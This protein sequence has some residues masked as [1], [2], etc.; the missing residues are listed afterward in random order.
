MKTE[1]Q[2]INGETWF[3]FDSEFNRVK[4]FYG[5]LIAAIFLI[6][7]VVLGLALVY[8]MLKYRADFITNPC[9]VCQD[10]GYAVCQAGQVC[11]EIFLP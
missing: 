10:F 6:A 9:L 1:T 11:Q 2:Q 7:M 8:I 4:Y 5:N 3:K